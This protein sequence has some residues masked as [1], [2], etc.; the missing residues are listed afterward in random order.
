[1]SAHD[2][3]INLPLAQEGQDLFG[4]QSIANHGCAMD[5]EIPGALDERLK[6]LL[7]VAD[8]GVVVRRGRG[9]LLRGN[10]YTVINMKDNEI[11]AELGG[12]GQGKGKGLLIGGK[13][14]GEEDGGGL[15]PPRLDGGHRK[16]LRWVFCGKAP[17]S[18]S[19]SKSGQ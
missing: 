7:P 3:V 14:R 11:R 9:V 5:A 8:L 12:L 18:T 16:L 15:A 2:D 10:V 19:K 6:T 4:G 1:M 17:D 13:L